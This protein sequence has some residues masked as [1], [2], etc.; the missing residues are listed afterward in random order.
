MTLKLDENQQKAV[1]HFEGPAV[2]V[3]GPGSGKTA[4]I[5]ERI[6]NLI[7][8][9]NINPSQI[10]ALAFNRKA[11]AEMDQRL[12][13]KLAGLSV[14]FSYENP[15]IC[16]LHA[17]G[18]RIVVKNYRKLRL[19]KAPSTWRPFNIERTI[20]EE[21]AQLK[22]EKANREVTIYKISNEKTGRCYYIGQTTNLQRREDEHLN[23]SSNSYLRQVILAEG[24]ESIK[25]TPIDR[26]KGMFA[27]TH[28]LKWIEHYK[29]L[30]VFNSEVEN[31]SVGEEILKGSVTIYKVESMA[32]RRCYIGYTTTPEW[33]E[34]NFQ[35]IPNDAFQ[36]AVQNEG[37]EQFIFEVLYEDISPAE[38]IDRVAD[39]IE[40]HKNRAIFNQ[41]N[42]LHQRY[43]DRLLIEF[44]CEHFKV[45]YE[46]LLKRPS[47]TENLAERIKDFEKLA[48]DVEKAK[49]E[50]NLDFSNT[51]SVEDIINAVISSI[52]DLVVRAFAEK[53]EKKKSK[54]NAID[55]Q[56]MIIYSTYIL[57]IHPDIRKSYCKKYQYVLVDEFQDVSFSD[58]RLIKLLSKNLFTVGDDDQAI[59]GFRGGNS[60]IMLD[61]YN[62]RDVKKYKITRN[63]RSTS[64]IVEHSKTLMEHNP[65][66]IGKDLHAKNTETYPPIKTLETKTTETLE[67]PFLREFSEPICQ[68]QSIDDYIPKLENT[69]L[70]VDMETQ[71]IGIL[72]RYRSEVE[73][74]RKLLNNSFKEIIGETHRKEGDPFS[75]V[76]RGPEEIIDGGTIHSAKGK[77]YD[78]VIFIHNT[79]EDKDFPFQDSDD[80]TEDRRVFYVAMTRAKRELVILGG[81]CQFVT[82][83]ELSAIT[84]KRK[85]QLEK[86]SK[87]LNTAI[88]HRIDLAKKIVD[89]LS[90]TMQTALISM[91]TK[92]IEVTIKETQAQCEEELSHLQ[93]KIE[94]A[95]RVAADTAKQLETQFPTDL[96]AANEALLEDLIPVLDAFKSQTN[97]LRTTTESNNDA[98]DFVEFTKNVRLAEDQLLYSLKNHG[99]KPIKTA[100][101]IFNPTYHEIVL[102]ATYSD[103]VIADWI[104]RE[105]K[106]GYQLSDQVIRKA[107]VI[108]SRG[109]EFLPPETLNWIVGRYLDRLISEFQSVYNLKNINRG[110]VNQQIVQYLTK[111]DNESVRKIHAFAVINGRLSG[112]PKRY[113]DYCVGPEKTHLCTPIFRD[114]W[115]RMWQ[116]VEQSRK[117]TETKIAPSSKSESLKDQPS[118]PSIDKPTPM[119]KIEIESPEELLTVR[120]IEQRSKTTGPIPE[121]NVSTLFPKAKRILLNKSISVIVPEL[122]EEMIDTPLPMSTDL[123][124]SLDTYTK[125]LKPEPPRIEIDPDLLETINSEADPTLRGYEDILTEQIQNLRP[126]TFEPDIV[127]QPPIA[128]NNRTQETPHPNEDILKEQIQDLRPDVYEPENRNNVTQQPTSET[129]VDRE[130]SVKSTTL[131]RSDSSTEID[132]DSSQTARQI[133]EENKVEEIKKSIGYYL[134]RG[135]RFA[136]EKI[137]ST[138]SKKPNS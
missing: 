25:F 119:L 45:N 65:N 4:V 61:F 28:E 127:S 30:T 47:D 59:Y 41:S 52:Q 76:G 102:P 39:E 85:K 70:K 24:R 80:I 134:R 91:L 74:L 99:L 35:H 46:E 104:V 13:P 121:T 118:Q 34:Q 22:R 48:S 23:D 15:E 129:G 42:P 40:A 109:P 32:T 137:K 130:T 97:S 112:Q 82:E 31:E 138:F 20:K 106:R 131:T 38:A 62:R 36:A 51:R 113:A 10:L 90:E 21:V 53:Y 93:I 11:A 132:N 1:E 44:F 101:E 135:G 2:V 8:E 84:R 29:N 115:N 9:Y 26:V 128:P 18:R 86:K 12:S 79:L 122:V 126:D 92:H 57:E 114:F 103:E 89:E 69:L 27:D 60:E 123:M 98:D 96:K 78:K 120:N 3:A 75:F 117:K 81:D 66:R 107:Q 94:K 100:G 63:Y 72:A 64:I 55:F 125:N 7:R 111:Q 6:L 54:A 71:T 87:V 110:F 43:S 105:E 136:V 67:C 56:D 33:V 17:F 88:M 77:E 95:Q 116:V 108:V 37:A 58:F 14:P 5:I 19:N 133:S 50:V 83:A 68:T 49:R 73:K 124:E 16:T